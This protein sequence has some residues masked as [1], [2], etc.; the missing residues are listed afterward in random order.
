MMFSK[1]AILM[2]MS[3]QRTPRL[4]PMLERVPPGFLVDA[5]W[6]KRFGVDP[7][8]IHNYAERGWL[9]RVVR[10]V[11]RR[12]LSR[13]DHSARLNRNPA[14]DWQLVL[15]SIQSIMKHEV[16]LGGLSALT[17]HGFSHYLSLGHKER[18]HLYGEVPSWLARLPGETEFIVR[19]TNL[20][21]DD[22]TGIE[23]VERQL[24]NMNSNTGPTVSPWHWPL[25]VSSPERAILEA[26]DE[27]PSHA[28][29][30]NLDMI[31]Q[32]LANLRPKHLMKLLRACQSIKVKRLF[33]VFADRHSHAWLKYLDKSEIDLGSGPRA[34]IKDG[35]IHPIYRISVPEAFMPSKQ[36]EGSHNA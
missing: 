18:I 29:F 13:T 17:F 31:F 20:F 23:N 15:L 2:V 19:S 12:P 16:H 11:Y 14:P 34:L 32:G 22:P 1:G 9:E 4:K 33:F 35:K 24:E 25:K 10:G 3:H 36:G 8:S 6:L 21:G 7:K 30:D 27:L 26:L 5:A 28:G